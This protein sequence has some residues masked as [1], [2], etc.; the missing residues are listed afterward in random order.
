MTFTFIVGDKKEYA[1]TTP[2][3]DAYNEGGSGGG[4]A[5]L[6]LIAIDTPPYEQ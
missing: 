3:I 5:N 2:I 1:I 4:N 6:K